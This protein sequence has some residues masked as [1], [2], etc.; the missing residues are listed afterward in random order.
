M[1]EALRP[2]SDTRHPFIDEPS[3]LP[4]AEMIDVIDPARKSELVI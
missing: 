2:Q 3:V 1:I 4:G